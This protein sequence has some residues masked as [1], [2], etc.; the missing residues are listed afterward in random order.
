[1]PGSSIFV[2]AII[3]QWTH[4]IGALVPK[5]LKFKEDVLNLDT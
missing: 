5:N 3:L 2:Q 1:M 4:L